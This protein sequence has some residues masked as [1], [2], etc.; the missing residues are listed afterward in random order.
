MD[1]DII[2]EVGMRTVCGAIIVE[3]KGN[4]KNRRLDY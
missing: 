1:Y 3:Q 2:G 4:K